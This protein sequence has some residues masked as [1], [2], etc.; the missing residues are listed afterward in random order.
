MKETKRNK[1]ESLE[2][3]RDKIESEES[4]LSEG[5]KL[6]LTASKLYGELDEILFQR[7]GKVMLANETPDG[8]ILFEEFDEK[9]YKNENKNA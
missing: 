6:L 2:K 7:A 1:L 3:I 9:D 4:S 5:V 8:N